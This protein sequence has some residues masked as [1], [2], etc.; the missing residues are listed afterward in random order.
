MI[1]IENGGLIARKKTYV[2]L[3]FGSP[4]C[5]AGDTLITNVRFGNKS[6]RA[7]T[8]ENLYKRTHDIDYSGGH[9]N[10]RDDG[11]MFVRVVN[12]K[13]NGLEWLPAIVV[14]AGPKECFLLK[15]DRGDQIKASSEHKFYTGR[16]Y[17]KLK[18]LRP[19]DVVFCKSNF[20]EIYDDKKELIKI[21]EFYVKA[22]PVARTRVIKDKK[23]G[24]NYIYH[25]LKFSNAIYEAHKNGLSLSDY[26]AQLN[27]GNNELWAVPRGYEIHH[28]NKDRNDNRIENLEMLSRSEHAKLHVKIG[29]FSEYKAFPTTITSIE[30]CGVCHCYDLQVIGKWHN[31]CANNFVVHN[32]GKTSLAASASKPLLID[33]DKGAYR[34][35]SKDRAGM[36][37]ATVDN[38]NTDFL[39]LISDPALKQYETIVI[40]TFGALVDMIIRDKFG[41]VMNPAKWG[42]VKSEVIGVANTLRM[43]GKSVLFLAHESEEKTDDKIVKRPQCQGKA[44]EELMKMLD[45]IGHTTHQGDNFVLEFGGDDSIY[46]G[47]TYG[48]QNRYVLPDIRIENNDF[49]RRVIEKQISD[50]VDTQ[51]S[52]GVAL[53]EKLDEWLTAI[54]DLKTPEQFTEYLNDLQADKDLTTGAVLKIKKTLLDASEKAGLNYDKGAKQFVKQEAK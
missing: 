8:I 45:F 46:V 33:L 5:I 1:K 54:G 4:K 21:P 3:V 20:R 22:H 47:N 51:E 37:V 50:Y 2:G 7:R 14:D 13:T 53:R 27:M 17:K 15:N 30:P 43:T 31:F 44:K 29:C 40:D 19:G 28:K 10:T 49:W 26:I 32:S 34:T 52:E 35:A 18:D 9:K 24:K 42:I 38:Y 12:E 11:Q 48:F 16:G 23:T 6:T 41:G 39:P 36:D 25:R